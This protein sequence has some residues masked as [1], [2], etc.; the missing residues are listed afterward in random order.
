MRLR[1]SINSIQLY[2]DTT[3][4]LPSAAIGCAIL[5]GFDD[6]YREPARSNTAY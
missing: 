1:Q 2:L 4:K 3:E 5:L 6:L